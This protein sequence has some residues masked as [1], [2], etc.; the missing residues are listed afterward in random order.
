MNK[1]QT[2]NE[3]KRKEVLNMMKNH[4]SKTDC[5]TGKLRNGAAC[6]R[7]GLV[8]YKGKCV[9]HTTAEEVKTVKDLEDKWYELFS[10]AEYEC[11]HGWPEPIDEYLCKYC[12][13][14]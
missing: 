1:Q 2:T 14:H 11:D 10:G 13:S 8:K 6:P 12:C 3:Q 4:H 9:R 5:C 7:P